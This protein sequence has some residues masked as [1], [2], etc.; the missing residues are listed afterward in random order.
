MINSWICLT[1]IMT[2]AALQVKIR[3]A[4]M[5]PKIK[6][7][8]WIKNLHHSG[9]CDKIQRENLFLFWEI[10]FIKMM[11]WLFKILPRIKIAMMIMIINRSF[12]TKIVRINM[13]SSKIM[14]L[15]KTHNKSK[16]TLKAILIIMEYK[17]NTIL[18]VIKISTL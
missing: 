10:L 15:A 4:I 16:K 1:I 9:R 12:R 18:R 5:I 17:Y 8:N 7:K 14:K 6:I 3:L 2:I 13:D 11:V